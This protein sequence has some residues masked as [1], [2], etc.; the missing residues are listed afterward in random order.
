MKRFLSFLL[1][2]SLTVGMW[3]VGVSYSQI[4]KTQA[5]AQ[6]LIAFTFD[7]GPSYLTPQLLDGLAALGAKATFFC[8]GANGYYSGAANRPSDLERMVREGHQV[9]NHTYAH[10]VPFDALTEAEI[11]SEVDRV[12]AYLYDAVG[13]TYQTLVRTPG[14]AVSDGIRRNVGAPIILWSLD[15]LD[16]QLQDA[17]EISRRI[18]AS[19]KD[20]AVILLHDLYEP[21]IQGALS[22]MQE[23]KKRGYEF[24]T[25]SEL[26]R[27]R[28]MDLQNG[29]VYTGAV[30][31][32][33][34][35]P[36]YQAP[37]IQTGAGTAAG[38][39]RVTLTARDSGLTLYYTTDGTEP[40][41]AST[42]YTGPVDIPYGTV[43]TVAGYDRFATRTPLENATVRQQ[44]SGVF[45]AA[46]YAAAYPAIARTFGMSESLL[47]AHFLRYGIYEGKQASP[48][49]SINYYMTH[50]ADL[51][52]AF[53]EDRMRYV[54]HF[55][56]N[57]MAE[58][59]RGC[60][61]FDPVSYRRQYADLRRSYGDDWA[62]YY[63]HFERIGYAEG[64]AGTGCTRMQNAA[65]LSGGV[66]YAAVYDYEYY[67]TKYPDI[68][69]AYGYDDAAVLRHF[70]T[71]GMAEGRRASVRF[72]MASYYRE[73]PD[74][75]SAYG[76]DRKQYYLHYIRSGKDEGRRG[77]GCGTLVGK[78]TRYQGVD[79][80][81]VF[82][83]TYYLQHYPD[84]QQTVGND[85]VAA[86]RHF[87]TV[88]M[89]E[90]RRASADFD[91]R[92]YYRQYA[93]LR[94]ALG[95]DAVKY[96]RHYMN[97]GKREGRAGTGCDTMQGYTTVLDGVDYAAVYDFNFYTAT[98]PDMM[99]KFGL[100]EAAALCHFVTCGMQEG[101]QASPLFNVQIYRDR[102]SDLDRLYGDQLA[103]Y[104]RH[105]MT[106]G[107]RE[108]RRGH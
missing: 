19:A 37:V 95:A 58:A 7:D 104:Y 54:T 75:R 62:S 88:G 98:Y 9:A 84:V 36:A 20:G 82:D 25:V 48:T 45:D 85:D 102:Y 53:G 17:A 51:K 79:Y 93:D 80:A 5:A 34:D 68:K 18:L 31:T 74:L 94:S 59:R 12:N 57:G 78:V 90:G 56:T 35:L 50:N 52:A 14:G 6:K 22:A 10:R 26:Y 1:C 44:Y 76:I 61:S 66:N 38:T 99:A 63:Y 30:G 87:V 15:T 96:Y 89:K 81:A 64:R 2:F 23:L 60:E 41:M 42:R 24:V 46:Y 73:H 65:V 4:P 11:R 28:G 47:L 105:Y 21:S 39:S 13:G 72:D 100:N 67:T 29:E 16:W 103:K 70:V 32:G 71:T 101:R 49:F 92:S 77:R 8:N 69:E 97:V 27:R 40:T 3:A 106:N 108:G 91:V 33:V 107:M 43:V 86:L 83:H 55:L